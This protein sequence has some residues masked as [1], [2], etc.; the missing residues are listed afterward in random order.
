MTIASLMLQVHAAIQT[1]EHKHFNDFL[2]LNRKLS[3]M[4]INDENI[5]ERQNLIAR[6][7]NI[8]K[9]AQDQEVPLL[10][11]V[12]QDDAIAREESKKSLH[13]ARQ[14]LYEVLEDEAYKD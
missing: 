8:L 7:T 5:E 2:D 14:E 10:P 3:K 9:V 12:L 6:L 1:L 4:S 11:I 13:N